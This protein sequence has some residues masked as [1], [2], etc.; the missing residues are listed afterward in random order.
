MPLAL[1]SDYSDSRAKQAQWS[2]FVRRTRLTPVAETLDAVVT[3]IRGLLEL[4]VSA[5]SRGE[6][7]NA[8]WEN[9]G[10]WR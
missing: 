3:D 2:A 4:P 1:T 10:P 9:G 7:L 6:R 8:V 5:A